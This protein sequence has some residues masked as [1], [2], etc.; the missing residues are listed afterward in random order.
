MSYNNFAILIP[1]RLGSTR[2]KNKALIEIN[3]K[4][5]IEH[6]IKG[7]IKSDLRVPIIVATDTQDI[8]NIAERCGQIGILTSKNHESGSDRIYEA[9]EKFDPKKKIKKIIH[10]QG[11]LPNVSKELIV[12]L[13]NI[14]KSNKCIATPVVQA[15]KNEI[16][17]DNIVKCA[18]SFKNPKPKIGEI[19]NALYF[20]RYAIPWGDSIKWHHLGL[21]GWDRSILEKY[22]KLRPSNLEISEKLEQLRALEAGINIKILITNEKPIGIDT[23]SDLNKFKK[24]INAY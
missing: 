21:Y 15:D 1:S 4:P 18:V 17:D 24:S 3:K 5:L 10:L 6:V 9:L 20:S 14:I 23:I 19:G 8:V 7:A 22:I 16:L 12:S 2:L 11:D 13:A